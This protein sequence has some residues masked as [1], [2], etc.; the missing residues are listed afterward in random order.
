MTD[1]RKMELGNRIKEIG[2]E[3]KKIA[4][5]W[6]EETGLYNVSV[7]V[8]GTDNRKGESVFPTAYLHESDKNGNRRM[9]VV[10]GYIDNSC[11]KIENLFMYD[12]NDIVEK[13]EDAD[14]EE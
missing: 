4:T 11:N 12:R 10:H 8:Q 7:E 14:E 13:E 3:L 9:V 1:E 5:E 2:E 6:R